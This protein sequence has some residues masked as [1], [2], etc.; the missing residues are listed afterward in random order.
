MFSD[1]YFTKEENSHIFDVI[2]KFLADGFELN[3]IDAADPDISDAHTIPDHIQLANQVKM[4]LQESEVEQ[5]FFG[6]FR[7]TI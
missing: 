5:T 4:C 3:S 7:K 2:L 6:D 1:E